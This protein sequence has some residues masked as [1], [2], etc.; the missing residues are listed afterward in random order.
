VFRKLVLPSLSI[1]ILSI[2]TQGAVMGRVGKTYPRSQPSEM[3]IV[4][5][6][7]LFLSPKEAMRHHLRRAEPL[8]WLLLIAG[9]VGASLAAGL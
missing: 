2:A 6:R 8:A 1:I 3:P 5:G 4:K 9:L 7:L